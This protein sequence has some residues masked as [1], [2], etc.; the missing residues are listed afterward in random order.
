MLV[1]LL[2]VTLSSGALCNKNAQDIYVDHCPGETISC[3]IILKVFPVDC[4]RSIKSLFS[5]LQLIH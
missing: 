1:Q 3:E 4:F 5:N 2:F